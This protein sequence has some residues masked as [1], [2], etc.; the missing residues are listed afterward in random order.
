MAQK[1]RIDKRVMRRH[2]ERGPGKK[3]LAFREAL[4]K[5]AEDRNVDPHF[6]MVDLLKRKGVKLE[7]K[8]QA[9]KELAQYLEPKLRSV[10][11]SGNEDKPLVIASAEERK[12]R[13]EELLAKRNGASD[14]PAHV[15]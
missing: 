8:L 2:G 1:P 4:R 15:G 7:L 11:V 6:W 9:A 10:E 3:K 5:Y 13:I 12:K 14:T